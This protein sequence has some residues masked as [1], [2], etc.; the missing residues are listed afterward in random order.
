MSIDH[1]YRA[2]KS[3]KVVRHDF[4]SVGDFVRY[5]S[6]TKAA[7][8]VSVASREPCSTNGFFGTFTFSQAVELAS[9]GW[10]EG[11]ARVVELREGCEAFLAAAKAAKTRGYGWDVT[12]DFIDVGRLLS[13]EP[14]CCGLEQDGRGLGSRVVSIRLNACVSASVSTDAITARGLTVLVAADLLESCGIRCEILVS[15][16]TYNDSRLVETNVCVKAPGVPIDI[17][18]LAFAIAHPSFFR[19]FGFA[20]CEANGHSPIRCRV[21]SLS[22]YEKREGTVEVDGV[23]SGDGLSDSELRANVLAIAKGCGLE[24]SDEEL[25]EITQS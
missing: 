7:A 11:A 8:D 19:R 15:Q 16:A 13:G 20:F 14:E 18:R 4:E 21:A 17:D 1:A 3:D 5:A 9:A 24:F 2:K 12:G 22:D 23:C 10:P 6:E 25:A